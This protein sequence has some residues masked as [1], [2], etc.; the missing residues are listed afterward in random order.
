MEAREWGVGVGRIE[1]RAL[2]WGG[3]NGGVMIG[4]GIGVGWGGG[5][6]NWA[7]KI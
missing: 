5:R 7:H 4:V 3:L 2:G 6:Y 1:W